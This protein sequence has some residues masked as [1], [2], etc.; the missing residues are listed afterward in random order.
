MKAIAIEE[1]FTTAMFARHAPASEFRRVGA[2]NV[3]F[4]VDWPYDPNA[5]CIGFLRN[6]PISDQDKSKIARLNTERVLRM[7]PTE[8][9]IT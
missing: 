1:H 3:L 2:D 7:R 8:T 4:V 6:M 5:T 9:H